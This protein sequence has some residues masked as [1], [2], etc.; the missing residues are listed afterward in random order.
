VQA[1]GSAALKRVRDTMVSRDRCAGDV[2]RAP[3]IFRRWR[4]NISHD[5][6][7]LNH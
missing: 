1:E 6:V 2:A 5:I 4:L 3:L 7:L